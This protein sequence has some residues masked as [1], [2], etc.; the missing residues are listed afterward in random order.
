MNPRFYIGSLSEATY[1]MS[2]TE[3]ASFP[4][5]NLS[6]YI[7]G[8]LWKSSA[9]TD[10]Q[11]LKIDFGSARPRNFCI[12]HSHN[13]SGMTAVS[14]QAATDSAYTSPVTIVPSLVGSNKTVLKFEFPTVNYRYWRILF[15][16]TNTTTP[17]LGQIY[18]DQKVELSIGTDGYDFGF[19]PKNEEAESV[20][21]RVA[22]SGLLR[23]ASTHSGQRMKYE[24]S[25]KNVSNR[26]LEDFRWMR[27]K[28]H[29]NRDWFY[30]YDHNDEQFYL[31]FEKP[32]DAAQ[33]S[34]FKLNASSTVTCETQS[35]GDVSYDQQT[36]P[37]AIE[38]D[39]AAD[40]AS[41]SSPVNLD[42]N[43]SEIL[44]NPTLDAN[45]TGWGVTGSHTIAH[46]TTVV[47]TGGGAGKV[48]MVSTASCR[49]FTSSQSPV[50]GKKYT[51]EVWVRVPAANTGKKVNLL[52]MR[53]DF[54]EYAVGAVVTL[55]GDT[56]TKVV[57]N[58]VIPAGETLS[59]W[60]TIKL[61]EHIAGDI[62]YWD[63]ASFTEAHDFTWNQW[64]KC[65]SG[66]S[67]FKFLS[68]IRYP[69]TTHWLALVTHGSD[70]LYFESRDGSGVT[71]ADLFMGNV[72]DNTWKLISITGDRDGNVVGYVN[73]IQV[74]SKS[75]AVVGKLSGAT[76][77]R[78]AEISGLGVPWLKG[79]EQ[80]IRGYAMT[81]AQI[82][83]I[84][85]TTGILRNYDFLDQTTA[86]IT[87][88]RFKG[89]S[90]TEF[91]KDEGGYNNLTG[92]SVDQQNNQKI[93]TY[94]IA[95]I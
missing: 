76:L 6:T 36:Y 89:D 30:F 91:L 92:T 10:G 50:V 63:D 28:L 86:K 53:S 43:G 73:A 59:F 79:D 47:R 83:L 70:Q 22:L 52:L 4:L 34:S 17:E 48:T 13:F 71:S 62:I 69:L 16:T 78:I 87:H 42:M 32:F 68:A 39:G 65:P 7:P 37:M 40:Y 56:W 20:V 2:L 25:W 85:N 26:W 41:K 72:F 82:S 24:M 46:E 84:Y 67:T 57:L 80:I 90:D 93:G 23:T 8:D 35:V 49:I 1:T 64:I 21:S 66:T 94:R 54:T 3:N 9:N 27:N 45:V 77:F 14:L 55:A 19:R 58:T 31:H 81:A 88:Y 5:S 75:L 12:I 95:E 44:S 11:T 74:D 29:G 38:L 60:P 33:V 51:Y 15:T 61:T 18:I